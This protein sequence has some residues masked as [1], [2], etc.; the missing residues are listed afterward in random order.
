M[1][2]PIGEYMYAVKDAPYPGY[3]TC[4]WGIR[5]VRGDAQLGQVKWYGAWRQYVFEPAADT[6]FNPGCLTNLAAFIE[7]VKNEREPKP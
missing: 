4:R 6:V 7:S 3:S 2:I 1:N 5:S